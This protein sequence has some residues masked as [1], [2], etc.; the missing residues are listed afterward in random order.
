MGRATSVK[1]NTSLSEAV[2]WYSVWPGSITWA[3]L[4]A[5]GSGEN[6]VCW[7]LGVK[8][9]PGDCA[10]GCGASGKSAATAVPGLPE[11]V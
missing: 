8:F 2:N 5:G 3:N 6:A 7:V 9:W 11:T 1:E 10:D 4:R